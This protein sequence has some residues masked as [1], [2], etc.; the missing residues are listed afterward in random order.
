MKTGFI[1]DIH[2]NL[3]ALDAVL[4]E[5]ERE[6]V[7]RIV[8]LGDVGSLG[9]N[10]E[11]VLARLREI[12]CVG[13][14]GNTDDW[15]LQPP[16]DYGLGPANT[17]IMYEINYWNTG[18]L[19]FGD[20]TYL[21]ARPLAMEIDLGDGLKALA[22]HGSPRS[23]DD[24]IAS[25]TPD[26]VVREML[27][28]HEADVF[29]GGHTHIQMMRRFGEARLVNV[30]SVGLPGVGPGGPELP[31]NHNVRWAEYGILSVEDGRL[32][33][34]LRRTPLDMEAVLEAGRQSGMPHLAWWLQKWG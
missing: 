21:K 22:Y 26:E 13:V 11:G 29:I 33:I 5:L 34:E 24:V 7:D 31:V 9:P 16:D 20:M 4:H 19:M 12:G 17:H 8:C 3:V 28:G 2:G 10:A 32:S 23:F 25:V 6:S 27:E 1:S 14:L 15:L 18:D 30:G